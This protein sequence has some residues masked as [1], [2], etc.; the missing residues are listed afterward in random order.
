M[1]GTKNGAPVA[2]NA[3]F[4]ATS[5]GAKNGGFHWFRDPQNVWFKWKMLGLNG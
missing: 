3:N 2:Y 5:T 4:S 1:S